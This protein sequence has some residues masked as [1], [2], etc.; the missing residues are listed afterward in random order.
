MR[1]QFLGVVIERFR[2]QYKKVNKSEKTKIL[3]GIQK[4][5]GVE[6]KYLI[7]LLGKRG[8]D[9][10]YSEVKRGRPRVYS[11]EIKT[12]ISRL[13]KLMEQISPKR[14]K[15]AIPL[16]KNLMRRLFIRAL[17]RRIQ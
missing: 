7:K 17:S 11:D 8:T 1:N 15:G 16:K 3:D 12:H 10:L 6:R 9:S 5:T 2:D 14:M 4:V 13:N